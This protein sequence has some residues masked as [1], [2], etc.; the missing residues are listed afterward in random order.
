MTKEQELQDS[1]KPSLSETGTYNLPGNRYLRKQAQ[2]K[3]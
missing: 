3:V 2:A 1:F